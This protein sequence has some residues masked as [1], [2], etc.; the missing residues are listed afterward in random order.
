VITSTCHSGDVATGGGYT[1]PYYSAGAQVFVDSTWPNTFA[2][3]TNSWSIEEFNPGD[4]TIGQ[5]Y[6]MVVC[7]T[8]VTVAGIGVPQFSSLY[9][10]I[11]LGAVAY[12]IMARRFAGRPTISA[13]A[14]A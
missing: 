6:V 13:G 10:A 9:A 3:A 14:K 11:A 2:G 8:P 12:F 1:T 7:Q 5:V 4:A